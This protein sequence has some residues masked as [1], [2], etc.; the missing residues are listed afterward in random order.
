MVTKLQNDQITRFKM[1]YAVINAAIKE[2]CMSLKNNIQV[3][4]L[5]YEFEI[6][7]R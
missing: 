1:V 6:I 2:I 4:V 7:V 5:F 3:T